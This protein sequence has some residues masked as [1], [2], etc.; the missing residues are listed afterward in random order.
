MVALLAL[1][2][3]GDQSEASRRDAG[4][5]LQIAPPRSRVVLLGCVSYTEMAVIPGRPKG[6]EESRSR[7]IGNSGL[8]DLSGYVVVSSTKPDES[9]S[10]TPP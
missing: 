1:G 4:S 6:G 9:S 10:P 3:V 8:E 2:G 7:T 5:P